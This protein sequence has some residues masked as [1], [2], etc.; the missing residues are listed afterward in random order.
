MIARVP[1]W[2]W[3]V[4]GGGVTMVP[5]EGPGCGAVRYRERIHPLRSV[6][7]ILRDKLADRR[8][9]VTVGPIEP[10]VTTE[11]EYA[12]VV[13]VLGM[14]GSARVQ[15]TLGFVFGDDWYSEIG[16]I[17]LRADQFERFATFVRRLVRDVRLSLGVRRRRFV[18]QPPEGWHGYVR[19]PTYATWFP[20]EH[21]ADP[22]SITV[23]PALPSSSGGA[24]GERL[25]LLCIG[26]PA[27]A[28]VVGEITPVTTTN[29]TRLSGSAWEF[30]VR[31]ERGRQLARRVVML[32]DERYLYTCYLDA[33]RAD[34]VTRRLVLDRLLE[35]IEPL[36]VA[37]RSVPPVFDHWL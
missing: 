24:D 2:S 1:G 31:D 25:D 17:A 30:E 9:I 11:G 26:P 10:L 35:S 14:Q 3:E 12:A 22:T 28:D 29:T 5:P 6:E 27:P 34:L 21:P 4:R 15:R 33:A 36:P 37:N 19:L 13:D 16:G 18:Y 23:Y 32:R 8:Q 20:P 7:A